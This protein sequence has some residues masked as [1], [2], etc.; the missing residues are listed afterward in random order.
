MK[1]NYSLAILLIL[2]SIFCGCATHSS[3]TLD[4]ETGKVDWSEYSEPMGRNFET[5]GFV[6]IEATL[7]GLNDGSGNVIWKGEDVTYYKLI[8]KAIPLNADAV[9]NIVID[10]EESSV[11]NSRESSASLIGGSSESK[12]F[13]RKRTATGLAIKYIN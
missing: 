10:T 6:S 9:I 7:T 3:N 2:V 12:T 8:E 1:I 13:I 5:L 11:I 4:F